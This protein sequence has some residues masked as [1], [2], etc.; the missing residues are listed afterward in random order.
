M[1]VS[2]PANGDVQHAQLFVMAC[3]CVCV[4]VG[5]GV[6]VCVWVQSLVPDVT[7]GNSP[8]ISQLPMDRHAEALTTQLAHN[9]QTARDAWASVTVRN[10]STTFVKSRGSVQFI[11]LWTTVVVV[12]LAAETV[13]VT[14]LLVVVIVVVVMVVVVVVVGMIKFRS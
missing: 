1:V 2:H 12:V 9:L 11:K 5:G 10:C 7:P 6:W 14:V 4:C 3:V 8:C 13:A